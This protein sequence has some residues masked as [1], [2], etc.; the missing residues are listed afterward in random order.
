MTAPLALATCIIP[1]VGGT[2]DLPPAGCTYN[3]PTGQVMQI[4]PPAVSAGSSIDITPSLHSFHNVSEVVGG[5]LGGHTQTYDAVLDLQI[6][7]MGSLFGYNRFISMIVAVTTESA[8]RTPGNAVQAFNTEMIS[9][10]GQQFG[11]PDFDFLTI[12]AGTGQGLPPAP[13]ITRLTRQGGVGNP[14]LV[15]SFFDLTYEIDFVGAP[16]SVLQNLG[17]PTV[18]PIRLQIGTPIPEPASATLAMA[19]VASLAGIRR[20]RNKPPKRSHTRPRHSCRA[21]CNYR[22]KS[23]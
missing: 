5:S 7:G 8:P 11:D 18:G 6:N 12:K 2:G 9:L 20:R 23:F 21:R 14:F 4:L 22:R 19:G 16:G 10:F 3:P 13:G 1:N 17:G 15:D